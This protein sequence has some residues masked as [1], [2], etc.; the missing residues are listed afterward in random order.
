MLHR[1]NADVDMAQWQGL[2]RWGVTAV[3]V[4]S[5][6]LALLVVVHSSGAAVPIGFGKSTLHNETSSQPTSLQFGPDGRLYVAQRNGLI[7]IYSVKRNGANNYSVGATET[8]R[9]IK[10]I[11]N[12]DDDGTLNPD[13][14]DRLVTG[15]LVR[16]TAANPVVYVTSSDP[17]QNDIRVGG[18]LNLDTNSSMLS[19]LTWTG[20]RWSKV[21]LVR[22]LPHSE[23]N[24]TVNGMQIDPTT[25]MLYVAQGGHTNMGAPSHSFGQLPEYAYSAAILEI[26]LDMIGNTTY[27]LPTLDDEDRLGSP[28]ANDPFGGNDGKNQARIVADGPVRVYAPGFRNNY[29]LL[30]ARSGKM[31][32]VDN[33]HNA[34]EGDIP[35]REGPQGT[36]TNEVNEPGVTAPETLHLV[37][38]RGYY[39]GHP[40]PTRGNKDN[41]FNADNQSPLLRANPVECDYRAPGPERGNIASFNSSTNGLAEYTASNFGGAMKGNLLAASFE[42]RI[43]RVKLN[44]TGD[45]VVLKQALFSSVGTRPLD[46]VAQGDGARF[47]GTIW[48]ADIG[49]GAIKVFEPNDYGG[50]GG[51][52]CNRADDPSLDA[53]GDGFSN[54]D[55]I[56]NGTNP[57]SSA[58][59]PPDYDGDKKS[60]L[61]DPD[62][63]NDKLPDTSDPF[64]VDRNNGTTTSLPVSYTWDNDTPSPGGLLNLGFT[65]LMTNSSANYEALYNPAKMTAAGAAGR[66]TVDAV[67]AGDAWAANNSQKY[68]FQFG[69]RADPA[70]TG[71]FTA[72][73]E[74]EAPFAGMTPQDYQSMGLFVGNGN[75]NNYLK[76]V[77]AAN[78]GAGGIEFA[79]E[80]RGTFVRDRP[81]AP[82]SL[83]GPDAVGLFLTVDPAAET[84]QPS[85]A[86]TTN[87]VTGQRK[88]LGGPEPIPAGWFGGSTGFA[89]GIISTSSGPGPVFPAT[90]NFIEV[91]P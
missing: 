66:V 36:C 46:V 56:D 85:Y 52:S 63:D 70:T 73:T 23:N 33:N 39:G 22:G 68:G 41:T 34:G 69:I 59:R 30:I 50:S 77:T 24:H 42:N 51:G 53:D 54:A 81:R 11:P 47:P 21:D 74:I 87:G 72:H 62:D 44:G 16:G 20:S 14:K 86:V 37:K 38:D 64:A 31:Y 89:V 26:D 76:L 78:G 75:Q 67:P 91:T 6:L 40:N 61:N 8:I 84:V 25:N 7:K 58:D 9:S 13:V 45:D 10:N 57:C 12:H 27:D 19:R 60:N 71:T 17:R 18:D 5:L 80:V 65:G 3:A 82:V 49:N 28:D 29:D 15:I 48:V 90:W 88:T 32:T 2:R 83:P 55:E 35:V 43:Y 4:A 79:K 1:P